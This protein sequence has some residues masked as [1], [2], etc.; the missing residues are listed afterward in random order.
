MYLSENYS[1]FVYKSQPHRYTISMATDYY[2]VLGIPK[3]ASE[4]DI[5]SAFRKLARQYHPDVN[6]GDADAERRFK[7]ISQANEVLGESKNRAAYDKYGDQWQQADQIEEMRKRQGPGGF[8]RR[9]AFS[10]N[11]PGGGHGGQSFQFEGDISDLFGAGAGRGGRGGFES[12]FR[13]AAGRQRGQDLEH[14]TS[15]TLNEAYHGATRTVQLSTG[16]GPGARIEVSIPAGVSDGQ[17]IRLS[18]KGAPGMNGGRAGDLFLTVNVQPHPSFKRDGDNLRIVVDVP[19]TD[20]A[21]GGEVHVP[22]LK[23]KSLALNVP[24]GTPAGGTF[25]MAG[26][27]MPAA[28]G[29]FGDFLAEIRIVL[30]EELTAEQCALF[31]QLRATLDDEP[32]ASED[33][34]ST[35]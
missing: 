35:E 15:V 22:T 3:G 33:S 2:E 32:A 7:E 26:Q 10:G 20:A 29:G 24:A 8:G 34:G 19:V 13:R 12:L 27:G 5:K 28:N 16:G 9:G 14:T 23:G 1:D 4:K 18:G 6:P 21:L 11:G 25:R 17:R 31:E 30:P